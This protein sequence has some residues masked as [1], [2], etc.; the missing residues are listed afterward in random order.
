MSKNA[1]HAFLSVGNVSNMA[2][3]MRQ[4]L[5]PT[6]ASMSAWIAKYED[7]SA[8]DNEMES[9]GFMDVIDHLNAKFY[10][11]F[12][13]APFTDI[14]NKHQGGR[15]PKYYMANT[16]PSTQILSGRPSAVPSGIEDYRVEDYRNMDC[17]LEQDIKRTNGNFRYNNSIM[18]WESRLYKRNYDREDVQSTFRDVRELDNQIHGYNMGGVI[19]PNRY[20]SAESDYYGF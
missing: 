4:P 7:I 3:K 18:K 8:V 1:K 6:H 10:S 2:K 14:L 17:F 11:E 9:V 16:L 19:G 13:Y 20:A 15:Y 5:L 12:S